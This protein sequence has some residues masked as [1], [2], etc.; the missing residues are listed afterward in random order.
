[1]AALLL[2]RHRHKSQGQGN[3]ASIAI[4][5][6]RGS[7]SKSV[8]LAKHL[9]ESAT[10]EDWFGFISNSGSAHC[11]GSSKGSCASTSRSVW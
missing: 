3:K 8:L 1:M 9:I 7:A 11:G 5:T 2:L 6:T 10:V 4:Q